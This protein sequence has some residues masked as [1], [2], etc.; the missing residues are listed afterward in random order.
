MLSTLLGWRPSGVRDDSE[1]WT[2]PGLRRAK[3]L[4]LG[5]AA[6]S[7]VVAPALGATAPSRA[8]EGFTPGRSGTMPASYTP[9]GATVA[10]RL[11]KFVRNVSTAQLAATIVVSALLET[12]KRKPRG[13]HLHSH[14]MD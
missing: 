13:L 8:P 7:T 14:S 3:D 2:T 1:V 11:S 4:L 10:A 12:A 9:L 6:F 5:G